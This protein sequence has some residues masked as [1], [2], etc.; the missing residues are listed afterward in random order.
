MLGSRVF[1]EVVQRIHGYDGFGDPRSVAL[2][3]AAHRRQ[4][5]R[6]LAS[7]PIESAAGHRHD[8]SLAHLT[9][10]SLSP[11]ELV[12]A[13]AAAGYRYVGLRMTKVTP[14]E[15]HYPLAYDP[16]LMR[17]TKTHL[18]AT[19]VE[20]LDIELARITSGDSPRD[21]LR[22]L[23]AGAELGARHV[24]AQL[25]DSDFARKTDRF[26][27]LCQLAL[28][29]GLTIDLE[30]PSWTE[31]P[32]L[33][34]ATRVLRAADQPNA[35]LL[36]DLLHFA[37]SR[38]SVEDLRHLPPEWFHYAHVCDAPAEIPETTAGLIHTAR[39]ERLFP[40][41][42]GIDMLGILDALPAGLPYALEI[43]RATLVAQVGGKEHARLAIAAA[44]RHLDAVEL[45]RAS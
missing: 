12:D 4:R 21:Y 8:Y 45:R 9:A 37:R 7:D 32:N 36:I 6:T 13:A 40:G 22:F 23:E 31:T 15:P 2:R 41:E 25:P 34:E 43:P 3:M 29:L 19:G 27:E 18:A 1:F 16:A 10:L 30:F 38:S 35:G 11:P 26:S 42:G 24:I 44:R 5:M 17:R 14:Q 28:P 33:E 20:V 39:F